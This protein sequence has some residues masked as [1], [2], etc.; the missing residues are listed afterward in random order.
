[1]HLV[2]DPDVFALGVAVGILGLLLLLSFLVALAYDERPLLGLAAY[3][4]LM[5]GFVLAGSR[6]QLGQELIQQ[7]LLVLGPSGMTGLQFWL[8]KT[9]KISRTG[10]A[11]TLAWAGVTAGLLGVS[12]A[13]GGLAVF[14]ALCLPWVLLLAA[15]SF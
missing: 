6:L 8:L 10:L 5:L 9:R 13:G 11:V 12:V 14:V 3:L 15:S 4:V 7:L 2:L 1:M